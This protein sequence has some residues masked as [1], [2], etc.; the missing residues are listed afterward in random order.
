MVQ[1]VH[2]I[3]ASQDLSG[4]QFVRNKIN[5]VILTSIKMK[6]EVEGEK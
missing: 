5:I 1:G 6:K 4:H 3:S 2:V